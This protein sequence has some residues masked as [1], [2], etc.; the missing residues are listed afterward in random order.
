MDVVES[1]TN[2]FSTVFIRTRSLTKKKKKIKN[3]Y[4]NDVAYLP[5][6][7]YYIIVILLL[8]IGEQS[9]WCKYP[10][11]NEKPLKRHLTK[12][13]RIYDAIYYTW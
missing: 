5:T 11:T 13:Y 3:T 7:Y 12:S 9:L 8:C 6:N 1:G 10:Y 2:E 4:K